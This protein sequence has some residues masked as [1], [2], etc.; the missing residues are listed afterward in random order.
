MLIKIFRKLSFGLDWGL[1]DL[2]FN[3]YLCQNFCKKGLKL[4]TFEFFLT[5]FYCLI[6]W[7]R[8]ILKL[9]K[10]MRLRRKKD[11]YDII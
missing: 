6:L 7:R 11:I 8:G 1:V 9:D 10:G 5:L 3:L 4:V 2:K